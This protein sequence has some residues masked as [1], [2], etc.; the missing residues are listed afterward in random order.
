MR[1]PRIV[2]LRPGTAVGS[3]GQVPLFPRIV[4]DVIAAAAGVELAQARRPRDG[5]LLSFE[6]DAARELAVDEE[7]ELTF[8][9]GLVRAGCDAPVMERPLEG[10]APYTFLPGAAFS[11]FADQRWYS[12]VRCDPAYVVGEAISELAD[13][14]DSRAIARA[15]AAAVGALKALLDNHA[16]E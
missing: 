1:E 11:D 9:F 8:V 16:E 12:A 6:P 14:G 7:A 4:T 3:G 2:E 5:G 13:G 15:A 10:L